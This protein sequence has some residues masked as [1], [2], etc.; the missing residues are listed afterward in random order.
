[1]AVSTIKPKMVVKSFSTGSFS[2]NTYY[3]TRTLDVSVDG[4]TAIGI[5]GYQ[6]NQAV[7][8]LYRLDLENN[9]VTIGVS[10]AN[11]QNIN[12]VSVRVYVLY[13]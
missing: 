4:L 3:A 11:Q 7:A 6:V 8:E 13:N 1:M 10:Y 2:A 12:N 5:V 9:T